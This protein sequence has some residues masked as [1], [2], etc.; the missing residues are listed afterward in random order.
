MDQKVAPCP[1]ANA[2]HQ[3]TLAFLR[4][5]SQTTEVYVQHRLLEQKKLVWDLLDKGANIYVCG[6][7]YV[8]SIQNLLP[9]E[10]EAAPESFKRERATAGTWASEE[11]AKAGKAVERGNGQRSEKREKPAQRYR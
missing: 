7:V 8:L 10:G 3:L 11:R 1:R 4:F 2:Y 6:Y 9:R 5:I